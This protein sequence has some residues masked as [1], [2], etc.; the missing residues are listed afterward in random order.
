M[1]NWNRVIQRITEEL[2]LPNHMLEKTD[3]ELI[4]Y[5]KRNALPKLENYCPHEKYYKL[6]T[7]D[8]ISK[9]E[10]N[11][12][13]FYIY[14]EDDREIYSILEFIHSRSGDY[15]LGRSYMGP[16]SWESVQSHELA[17]FNADNAILFSDYNY[18]FEFIHPNMIRI[19]PQWTG[20]A[21]I[22]YEAAHD[23]ELSTVPAPYQELFIELCMGM[24]FKNIGRIRSRYSNIQT[25]F[26]EISLNADQLITEGQEIYDKTIE[27]LETTELTNVIFDRG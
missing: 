19:S 23:P 8:E 6:T 24:V 14:D 13:T 3:M 22:K 20:S 26:G 10:G 4:D 12:S 16:L 17:N 18:N 7:T 1:L 11:P 2:A 25:A 21:I 9:V 27:K 5:L 15:L